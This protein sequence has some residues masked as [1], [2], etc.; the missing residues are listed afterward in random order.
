MNVSIL[1]TSLG[2]IFAHRILASSL[3]NVGLTNLH[4]RIFLILACLMIFF[5][6]MWSLHP[7]LLWLFFG[8][9][10]ILLKF[11]PHFFYVYQ[12]KLI[13]SQT[14]RMLD[15]LILGVQSG[16]TLRSSLVTLSHQESSLLRVS[17]ENLV[18]AIVF[19]NSSASLKSAS[20]RNL[21]DELSRI[22]KSQSKCA[23]QLRSLRKNLKI[24]EDFRR[25]SGQVSLQIRL[26]AVISAALYVG[27]L[28]FMI[29]QFGFYQH[30]G[31]IISSGA[32]FF[33][34]MVTVF[35]IGKR[36]QWNT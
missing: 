14:L 27:L 15:H 36:F 25:R 24:M 33:S 1:I 31:L 17:L 9:M 30:K 26:Q 3:Q 19:E 21:F 2:F 18:H 28:F 5:F 34:G 8:S 4:A 16:Q 23:D 29:T 12:E 13:Q 10:F 22:E 11:L 6:I 20:L 32:L 7:M 35:V